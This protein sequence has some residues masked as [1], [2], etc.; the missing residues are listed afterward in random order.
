MSLAVSP[1]PGSQR[2]RSGQSLPASSYLQPMD[3]GDECAEK[4]DPN[5][6]CLVHLYPDPISNCLEREIHRDRLLV[7]A[8][9][10]PSIASDL[11]IFEAHRD[12][13]GLEGHRARHGGHAVVWYPRGPFQQDNSPD[14]SLPLPEVFPH[15]AYPL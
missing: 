5:K 8:P 12:P 9:C 7:G 15:P 2:Y 13:V 1:L 4:E 14:W 10:P 3:H 11:Y 6:Y